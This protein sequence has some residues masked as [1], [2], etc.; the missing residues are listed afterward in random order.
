[1]IKTINK[2][3]ANLLAGRDFIILLIALLGLI[4]ISSMVTDTTNQL[5]VINLLFSIVLI[6]AS[7]CL[8]VDIKLFYWSIIM[9]LLAITLTWIDFVWSGHTLLALLKFANY[10]IFFTMMLVH[11]LRTLFLAEKINLNIVF[12]AMSGYIIY[13]LNRLFLNAGAGRYLSEGLCLYQWKCP[14]LF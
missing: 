13:R 10:S 12:A 9:G 3:I 4:G 2:K 6:I 5:I 8:L 7:N 1:M 14:Y 11:I